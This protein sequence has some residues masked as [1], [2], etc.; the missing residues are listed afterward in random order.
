LPIWLSHS[1]RSLAAPSIGARS[2]AAG[3]TR[4]AVA[5]RGGAVLLT[6]GVQQFFVEVQALVVQRVAHAL[7]LGAQVCLVV[8]VGRVLDRDL[9]AH[10]QAV[11]L[12]PLDLLRGAGDDAD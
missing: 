7:G 6:L 4:L 5:L 12:Q 3:G 11:P 10:R 9:R 8:G 1:G 2:A